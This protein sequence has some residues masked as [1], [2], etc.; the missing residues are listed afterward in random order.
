MSAKDEPPDKE[1]GRRSTRPN[2]SSIS[3]ADGARIPDELASGILDI[4]DGRLINGVWEPVVTQE[5]RARPFGATVEEFEKAITYEVS[6][7]E[8]EVE[9]GT[10]PFAA[11]PGAQFVRQLKRQEEYR[12]SMESRKAAPVVA[13]FAGSLTGV[14]APMA[15]GV[16]LWHEGGGCQQKGGSS[17]PTA[18]TSST[19]E[20]RTS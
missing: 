1:G 10:F 18:T 7:L 12:S 11:D 8:S 2:C 13:L 19:S 15:R 5:E 3:R 20:R 4:S 16:S 17:A 9:A 6:Q 14:T